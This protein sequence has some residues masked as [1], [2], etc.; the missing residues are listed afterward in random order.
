MTLTKT[1]FLKDTFDRVRNA[2]QDATL[3]FYAP[4][5][6]KSETALKRIGSGAMLV[7]PALML[8]GAYVM[9]F[10]PALTVGLFYGAAISKLISHACFAERGREVRLSNLKPQ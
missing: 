10:A 5:T 4:S 6:S 9:P 7:T 1:N 3:G 2:S 8:G